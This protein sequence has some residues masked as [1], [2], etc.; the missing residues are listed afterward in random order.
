MFRQGEILLVRRGKGAYL[1]LWSL[2]GGLVEP[3]EPLRAAAAR[4]VRE[5]TGLAVEVGDFVDF[6]EILPGP[7]TPRHYVLMIFRAES[8]D[9]EPMAQDDAADARFVS[10]GELAALPT[11]PGLAEV[12]RRAATSDRSLA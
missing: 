5:E 2:P 9:G 3:G 10:P 11:T 4:E 12:V 7:D 8:D 6:L 1:G